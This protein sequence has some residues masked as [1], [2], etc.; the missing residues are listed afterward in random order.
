MF[1]QQKFVTAT[2]NVRISPPRKPKSFAGGEAV[3]IAYLGRYFQDGNA[4]GLHLGRLRRDAAQESFHGRRWPSILQY[5]SVG[6]QL[7]L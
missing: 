7:S 1:L 3:S 6:V 4:P 5:R 2:T